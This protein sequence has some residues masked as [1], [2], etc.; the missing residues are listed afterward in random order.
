M[1][2]L[3]LI[4]VIFALFTVVEELLK[5]REKIKKYIAIAM[6]VV[7]FVLYCF[8]KNGV[9][10]DT[11]AYASDYLKFYDMPIKEILFSNYYEPGWRVLNKI[12][13]L[14]F[15]P[16]P[17]FIRI[18][19]YL[20]ITIAY[21][22]FILKYSKKPIMSTMLFLLLGFWGMSGA[23]LRQGLAMAVLLFS[24]KYIYEK[25]A[26][27]FILIVLLAT[28]FHY[29]AATF[30]IALPISYLKLDKKTLFL[31]LGITLIFLIF[32]KYIVQAVSS[33]FD[34][35][36]G[37]VMNAN[38]AFFGIVMIASYAQFIYLIITK[39]E[40]TEVN[41]LSK[42]ILTTP[43]LAILSF[44]N[45][46]FVR[47]AYIFLAFEIIL[48][49]NLLKTIKLKKFYYFAFGGIVLFSLIYYIFI[50]K[51]NDGAMFEYLFF[52]QK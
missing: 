10:Y 6:L 9:F 37:I 2:T 51:Y 48:I 1:G 18:V 8:A 46:S 47:L 14:I 32:G 17:I 38:F 15:G 3:L 30:L 16:N 41:F 13:G 49:P 42:L 20:L 44:Y 11:G 43:F 22:F 35:D 19:V 23:I 36:Y 52:W 33:L 24:L 29:S 40:D 21:A 50:N 12:T 27:K 31:S 4:S 28:S 5:D 26:F 39:S 34:K 25:K 45:Y 7:L